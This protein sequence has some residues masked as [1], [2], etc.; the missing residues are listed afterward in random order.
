MKT[1]IEILNKN[2]CK[3]RHY[4][5]DIHY[6]RKNDALKSMEEYAEQSKSS[7]QVQPMVMPGGEDVDWEG[8]IA[9]IVKE[10]MQEGFEI[11]MGGSNELSEEEN[12]TVQEKLYDKAVDKYT[13]IISNF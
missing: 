2:E 9:E 6:I 3:V 5:N 4:S 8:K 13:K 1:A 11:A 7:G 10:I 12:K